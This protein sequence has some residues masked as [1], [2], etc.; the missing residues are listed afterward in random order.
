MIL[1]CI[2]PL[3]SPVVYTFILV[4]FESLILLSYSMIVLSH[5]F[6]SCLS[7]AQSTFLC[8]EKFLKFFKSCLLV[9]IETFPDHFFK[10]EFSSAIYSVHEPCHLVFCASSFEDF[11]EFCPKIY[12]PASEM[13]F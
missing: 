6:G 4:C 9:D 2:L 5:C 7:T 13:V 3:F 11:T 12:D 10:L 8:E 1:V